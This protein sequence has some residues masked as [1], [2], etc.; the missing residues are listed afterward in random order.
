[1]N[2]RIAR[3]LSII[4]AFVMLF[5]ITISVQAGMDRFTKIKTYDG[6]FADV[7]PGDWFYGDIANAYCYGLANGTGDSF[8]PFGNVSIAEAITF[9]ARING[10]YHDRNIETSGAEAWYI[11]NIRYAE[12]YGIIFPGQFAGG[13]DAPATRAQMGYIF[14]KALPDSEYTAINPDISSIADMTANDMYY[15]EILK[16]YRA[17]IVAGADGGIFRPDANI[18]R[19]EAAAILNRI[20]DSAQRLKIDVPVITEA[21]ESAEQKKLNAEEVLAIAGNSVFYIEAADKDG[22]ISGNGSGFFI[23][24]DGTAVTSFRVLEGAYSAV[25]KTA[26][27]NTYSATTVLGYDEDRDISIIK[28][29]GSGFTALSVA[30]SDT[31]YNGQKIFC[32]GGAAG[33][34]NTITTGLVA[35]ADRE[36]G[37]QRYIHISA[38]ILSGSGGGAALNEYAQVVG[39]NTVELD[40]GQIISVAVPSNVIRNISYAGMT[41]ESIT[42]ERAS[43]YIA[44]NSSSPSI[45]PSRPYAENRNI[46][47]Y[48]TFTTAKFIE[49]IYD[50]KTG[51]ISYAYE[52]RK[53]SAEGY[54]EYLG[55]GG[56]SVVEVVTNALDETGD[57]ITDTVIGNTYIQ[58]TYMEKGFDTLSVSIEYDEGDVV[59]RITF[60]VTE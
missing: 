20:V 59:V 27:G 11:G 8:A 21:P 26:D 44:V 14:S 33:F 51:M 4:L 53:Y 46:T 43:K 55:Y 37:G 1:M 60:N 48:A 2:R 30:D 39:V 29:D 7:K 23:D 49:K 35:N 15:A 19:A 50:G 17:G 18:S 28:V 52:S 41:M 45:A 54:V 3:V 24:S 25:V 22:K 36:I 10:I 31:V 34:E 58:T 12:T 56:W 9:A 13:Y 42:K 5:V 57:M 32:I 47:D 16:L 38:P 40:R 6:Q